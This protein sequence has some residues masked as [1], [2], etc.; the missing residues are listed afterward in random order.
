VNSR[1]SVFLAANSLQFVQRI[2]K[3]F[4]SE[5]FE[6]RDRNG[7]RFALKIEKDKSPRREMV[8]KEARYLAQANAV[9]VGPNLFGFDLDNRCI[10]MELVEGEP[11]GK[12]VLK[13][14]VSEKQLRR[15]VVSLLEQAKKLD[16]LG[17]DHGQ[18]AGKGKNILV[19]PDGEPVIIDF[20]KA[21]DHRKV[22]NRTQLGAFLFRNPNSP[23]AKRVQ[24]LLGWMNR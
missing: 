3:G 7:K 20:E 12:W 8:Q 6:V 22:H 2:S 9:G 18:L 21:S 17:L 1:L 13:E 4:S 15:V 5:V 10:L 23:V 19:K 24:E 14:S 16:S 11:F